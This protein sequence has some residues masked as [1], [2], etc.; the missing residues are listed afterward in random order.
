MVEK[1]AIRFTTLQFIG[2]IIATI[3][4]MKLQ[5]VMR[6]YFTNKRLGISSR[7]SNIF[8][9]LLFTYSTWNFVV[10]G[11]FPFHTV[12]DNITDIVVTI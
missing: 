9:M 11:K 8:L 10:N 12:S 5:P 4:F 6:L 2:I 3:L 1:E 7:T